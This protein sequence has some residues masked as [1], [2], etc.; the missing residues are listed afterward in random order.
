MSTSF[1]VSGIT[2]L[3]IKWPLVEIP[4]YQTTILEKLGVCVTS[5]YVNGEE[6]FIK[7]YVPVWAAVIFSDLPKYMWGGDC[8]KRYYGP[9]V[10]LLDDERAQVTA[11]YEH[12]V[13]GGEYSDVCEDLLQSLEE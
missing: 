13:L 2:A 7:Y 11:C 12:V 9:L 5:Q 8:P 1:L 6:L 4:W 10:E 3:M